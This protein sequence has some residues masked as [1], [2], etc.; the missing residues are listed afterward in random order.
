[1]DDVVGETRELPLERPTEHENVARAK[2][3]NPWVVTD[4]RG[5]VRIIRPGRW[6][7]PEQH[8][9]DLASELAFVLPASTPSPTAGTMPALPQKRAGGSVNVAS[10]ASGHA[11]VAQ[12]LRKNKLTRTEKRAAAKIRRATA[13]RQETTMA[14]WPELAHD[15]PSYRDHQRDV[16]ARITGNRPT[17]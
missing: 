14:D 12:E 3:I 5:K 8:Q 6:D 17:S 10:G 15:E 4:N 2:W 11:H 13:Y 16:R 7:N 9:R 1:M